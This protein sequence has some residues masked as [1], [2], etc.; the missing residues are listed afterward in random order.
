MTQQI[1]IIFVA[2]WDENLPLTLDIEATV[3]GFGFM[4]CC[5]HDVNMSIFL[6]I[7][8]IVPRNEM[9]R[10]EAWA[11]WPLEPVNMGCTPV[12]HTHTHTNN[13]GSAFL[14]NLHN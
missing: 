3:K 8:G 7:K 10:R 1:F 11:V 13:A 12:T 4:H 6:G 14:L 2:V 9:T 5:S